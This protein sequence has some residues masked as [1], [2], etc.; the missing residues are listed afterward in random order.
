MSDT[1]FAMQA[2]FNV[3]GYSAVNMGRSGV[4]GSV[5]THALTMAGVRVAILRRTEQ[6]QLTSCAGRV[7]SCDF[8]HGISQGEHRV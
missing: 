6:V 2:R 8:Y 3:R 1:K 7:Q 5:M 4:P